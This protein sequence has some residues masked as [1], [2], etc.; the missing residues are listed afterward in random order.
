MSGAGRKV[1]DMRPEFGPLAAGER[2]AALAGRQYGVVSRVQLRD[3][4]LSD[5]AI[6]RRLADGRLLHM[7]HGVYAVGHSVL[8]VRGRWMSAVLAGGPGAVL[9]HASAAAFWELRR[10][11]AVLI[12][13]TTRRTGRARPGLRIHRPRTLRPDET[14][15][16]DAIPVTTPA[17]TILDLAASLQAAHLENVLDRNEILELTDYPSLAAL[18]RAHP[19]HNGSHKLLAT[20]QAHDAGANLT[21]SGLEVLFRQLCHDHGLPQP[22]VNTTVAGKEVD[23][24]F[25]PARLIVE[26]DSWRYH[27][28]RRAFEDD[29][30]RDVLTTKAG[31]RTLR[32][33]DRQ[34]TEDPTS[35][36]AA[37][38]ALL[39]DRRAA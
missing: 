30:A 9:S 39:P 3:L 14:T 8:T 37:I 33:T 19:G 7:H 26:A 34:L 31:Y 10:S 16:K 23:F 20:L 18:A 36:A 2:I 17:R 5:R 1:D 6:S 32:F 35:V 13:V 24:L 4:G 15:T 38:A 25:E 27:K 28:T 22:R 12:D 21:R 11:S 29:R